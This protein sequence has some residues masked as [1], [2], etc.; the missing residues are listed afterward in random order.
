MVLEEPVEGIREELAKMIS[1]LSM[2]FEVHF[3]RR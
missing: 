2:I 3:V 1:K